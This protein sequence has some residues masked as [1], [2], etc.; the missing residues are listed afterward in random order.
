MTDCTEGDSR[1]VNSKENNV[2]IIV[3]QNETEVC[4]VHVTIDNSTNK[5]AIL[6]SDC[7]SGWND[8]IEGRVEVCSSN[9]F[10]SVCDDRWDSYDARVVCMQLKSTTNCKHLVSSFYIFKE[11]HFYHQ[12][13]FL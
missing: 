2:T 5:S 3:A 1:L 12:I 9:E 7:R 13:H 8:I 11:G 6:Q 4:E 10:K